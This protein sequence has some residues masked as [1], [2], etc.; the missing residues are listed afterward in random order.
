HTMTSLSGF[1]ALLHGRVVHCY[2]GPFYAGWGLTVDHFALPA[3]GRP[4]SLDGL[5]YAVMLAYPR[6]VLPDMAGFAAAEQVMHHLAQQA[7][8]DGASLAGGWLARK[9]RKGKALAEL[10]R[11]EWQAGK[12]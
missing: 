4:T 11:G 3:R 7:R 8:G 6:Y 12:T 10:L 9:L 2:G 1:E 5:V